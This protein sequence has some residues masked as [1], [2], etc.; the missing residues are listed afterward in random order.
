[1]KLIKRIRGFNISLGGGCAVYGIL[2]MI[3]IASIAAYQVIKWIIQITLGGD[4]HVY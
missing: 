2:S 3:L 1:M 4:A